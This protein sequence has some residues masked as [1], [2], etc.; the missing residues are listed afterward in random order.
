IARYTTGPSLGA[1]AFYRMQLP[2]IWGAVSLNAA[3]TNGGTLVET[4]SPPDLSLA[5][6]P[7]G[8]GRL[9]VELN[10]RAFELTPGWSGEYGPRNDQHG[11]RVRQKLLGADLRLVVGGLSVS[12][13]GVIVRQDPGAADK[14]NGLGPQTVVS[15]FSAEGAYGMVAYSVPL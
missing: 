8:S 9:G 6:R 1:K 13:E 7:I 3:L 14:A 5:G 15:A 10:Q 12:A 2:S 4:L 11:V